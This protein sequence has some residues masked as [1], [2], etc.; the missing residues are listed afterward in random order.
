MADISDRNWVVGTS[1]HVRSPEAT[2]RIMW[3]V[4]L[5]LAPA[6]VW[7]V[8]RFGPAALW[9][10]ALSVGTAVATEA[11]IEWFMGKPI[12][13][14]D[15]SAVLT[16]LLLAYVL[17][18]NRIV[19][20]TSPAPG[21]PNVELSLLPW[22]VP[23]VGAFVA[24]A[25][26]KFCFGG[27]GQNVWNPALVGRAFVQ[28]SFPTLV[29]LPS[30]PAPW[31][32]ALTQASPLAK[33]AAVPHFYGIWRPFLGLAPGCIG[34][35]S[36]VLLLAGGAYLVIR[37]YVDWTLVVSYLAVVVALVAA[38]PIE[39]D[40]L[41]AESP[42]YYQKRAELKVK[43]EDLP[44]PAMT[45]DGKADS[46]G[47]LWRPDRS[48][49]FL[50]FYHL[51]AGGLMLGAIFMATDMVT[52]PLTR[53]GQIIFGVGCGVLTATMRFYSGMPEGVCYSILLMNTA[54]PLI[55]RYTRPRVF[56]EKRK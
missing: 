15:G 7:G 9:V 12:T 43:I 44:G 25:I 19:P 31:S 54:C 50:M 49:V 29:T 20:L 3:R 4:A 23:V 8:I 46:P 26:A 18:S 27:L 21:G 56:G 38:L 28:V 16:G 30:W 52:S 32:D 47:S 55:D 48:R 42:A 14:R 45:A 11:A 53:K 13:I 6:G 34:E 24:I 35:V 1:P 51:F 5:A 33:S 39:P 37:K 22:Y 40:T 2:S 41:W 10:I 17:P 36:A